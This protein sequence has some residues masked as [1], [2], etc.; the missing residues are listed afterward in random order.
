M[1]DLKV[2]EGGDLGKVLMEQHGDF[3][4]E[5]LKHALKLVMDAE[6]AV[7]CGAGLG[8]RTEA[9]TNRRNGDLHPINTIKKRSPG[10]Q[11]QPDT[12]PLHRTDRQQHRGRVPKGTR[13]GY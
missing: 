8:E 10:H 7:Q 9:R 4:R 11:D 5:L 12:H 3:L 13:F 6:M 2:D 1:T